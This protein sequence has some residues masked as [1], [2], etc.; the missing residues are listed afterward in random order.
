[1]RLSR[2]ATRGFTLIE[3]MIVIAILGILLAIAIPAYSDYTIRAQVAEG[4]TMVGDLKLR[5]VEFHRARG[6]F[7]RDNAIA[8]VAAPEH[9]IG[10]YVDR[11]DVA[12]GALHIRFGHRVNA[13]VRG[14]QLTIRPAYV[15]AAPEG[16]VSWI[17]G[18]AEAVPGMTASG[19]D[20]TTIEDRHLPHACRP[21]VQ[22][23]APPPPR[24]GDAPAN[25]S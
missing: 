9:L 21:W 20:R 13:L 4:I 6:R 5:V 10:N 11:I 1:M 15:T 14:K 8:G 2:S 18:R 24:D 16:P 25:G 19:E 22:D 7:P 12:D 23:D 3:L 17:C